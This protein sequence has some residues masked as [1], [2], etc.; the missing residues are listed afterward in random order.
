[1]PKFDMPVTLVKH[2]GFFNYSDLLQAIR[3]WYIDDD[4]EVLNMPMYKQ[5]F[6]TTTGVEHE[7]KFQGE[8]NVTEYVKFRMEIFVRIYNMRD[9]EIIH[10]GKKLKMQEGQVQVEVIPVLEL[11]WQSRFKGPKPWKDFLSAL[12]EFYRNYIIK[13]KIADYWE[14]MILLKSS[15]LARVIK[16]ALGQEVI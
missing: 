7:F 9:V 14:D 13:Y 1:M 3:K 2:R 4:Y 15:Q 10:E 11:D 6:P 5:K 8:K 16:E 12:D